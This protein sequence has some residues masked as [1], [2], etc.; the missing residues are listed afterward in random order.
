MTMTKLIC[1]E[2]RRENEAE[3]IYCHDC[4]AKLDRSAVI[5][6]KPAADRQKE[7]KRVRN[8]FDPHRAKMR[9]LFFRVCK[10][11]LGA[12]LAAL[13]LQ[14]VLPPD[15]PAQP[16]DALSL[17]QLGLEIE[18]AVTYHRPTPLRYSED[19]VNEY[20][21]YALKGKQKVLQKPLLDFKRAVVRFS[22]GRCNI[23]VERACYGYPLYAS[24]F[25]AVRVSDGKID[26]SNKGGTIG[27]MPIYPEIMQYLDIVFADL[28]KALE[29]DRK[30][31]SKAAAIEFH[32]KSVVL[33]PATP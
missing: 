2:C 12:F 5:S 20:L 24:T 3:R 30:L 9:L 1:P 10:L 4:G 13:L 15:I 32:D 25:L 33:S 8:M 22:E 21:T 18:N 26:V 6:A 29:R 28:W 31:V 27:R 17:S 7:S 11:I 14:I 23:T 19:Q 16:K